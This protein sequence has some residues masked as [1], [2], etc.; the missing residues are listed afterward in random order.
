[1]EDFPNLGTVKHF[2]I[3][4]PLMLCRF[5][6]G[7]IRVR[8]TT[9]R[10]VVNDSAAVSSQTFPCVDTGL[11]LVTV[12]PAK[13]TSAYFGA[14]AL[15]IKPASLTEGPGVVFIATLGVHSTLELALALLAK[16]TTFIMIPSLAATK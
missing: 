3:I 1:M 4:A 7:W 10:Y 14:L 12:A 5:V 8:R 15:H 6:N 16:I 9:H 2:Q 13:P 11:I